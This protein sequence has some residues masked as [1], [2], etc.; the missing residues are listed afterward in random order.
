MA[1]GRDQTVQVNQFVA[2]L[3]GRVD[4][5]T[6]GARAVPCYYYSFNEF[7]GATDIVAAVVGLDEGLRLCLNSYCNRVQDFRK[8]KLY[9][10]FAS[11]DLI[12]DPQTLEAQGKAFIA[13][14][15][16]DRRDGLAMMGFVKEK[17]RVDTLIAF[18]GTTHIH[19]AVVKLPPLKDE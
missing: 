8:T 12:T 13:E 3:Y 7:F 6:E 9:A 4:L 14:C 16:I 5:I 11:R 1:A 2:T 15:D 17:Y 10:I 19:E 18:H